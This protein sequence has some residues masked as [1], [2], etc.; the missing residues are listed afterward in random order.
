[1]SSK[2]KRYIS[3]L[4]KFITSSDKRA[5]VRELKKEISGKG[6]SH[7]VKSFLHQ[8]VYAKGNKFRGS[9][10]LKPFEVKKFDQKIKL[11]LPDTDQP[12]IT[13][14]IPMYNQ[15]DYTFDCIYSVYL[16]SGFNDYEILVA[17][18]NSTENSS[19]LLNN[20]KHLRVIKNES[21]L[22]F[23][24]NCKN[25]AAQARGK[26]L[27]FLNNDTY[28]LKNWLSE[29]LDIFNRL[30]NVGIV[31]SKLV[32]QDG[33]LQE[34]GGILWQ[35]GSGWNY[36]NGDFPSKSEY[37]YIKEADYVSGA[38][39]MISKKIWDE[40]GGFDE[41]YVPAYYEDTDLCFQVRKSGYKVM[42][43]PFSTV[44]HFEGISHGKNINKGVKQYQI[45]N[46]Q[47]FIEK[48]NDVLLH[49]SRNAENVF[50]ERDRSGGKKHI[51]I[52]DHYLPQI[53][54][55]AGSKCISNFIDSLLD[56]GYFVQ[57]LGENQN[58][59]NGYQEQFQKKGI[60]VLYGH[61]FDFYNQSYCDYLLAN[62]ANID[63]VLLSRSS[64]CLPVLIFLRKNNFQGNIIY[65][66]H[67][68]GYLRM[69][70][71][72]LE[73]KDDLLMKS[74]MK[75][76]EAEDFMY[77]NVDNSLVLSC[78]EIE[79]LETYIKNPLHYVPAY[80]FDVIK[81]EADYE[82]RSGI[83]F[84]GGFNHPPNSDAIIWFLNEIYQSIHDTNI[85][86]T[87]VGSHMPQVVYEYQ[88]RYPLLKILS[89][90]TI[91]DLNKLYN[92]TRIA[93]VPLRY[94]A[95]V[96]GKVIE[97]MSLGVP[98][99]GTDIAFEGMPK[100]GKFLYKGANNPKD[101]TNGIMSIYDNK[102]LWLELSDF[103]KA[104]VLENYNKTKMMEV[105]KNVIG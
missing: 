8:K 39:L 64:V 42:Y 70:K 37:N 104:Y 1:M 33:K 11:S 44:V 95:G 43:Q 87:I 53:D 24:R 68:L 71:E 16:N 79:Y 65:F 94:G 63:V 20:F 84:V 55:D 26:Y 85:P 14:I 76:K 48:W 103:G 34:A 13:I 4:N 88:K 67:D 50:S 61:E 83:L 5:L 74:A 12:L 57:F 41:R 31:G 25:A 17:D 19:L 32:Y 96:K 75:L 21:N 3:Y 2:I 60:E 40:I 105:F 99:V 27:I 73:K 51:L 6:V 59:G 46:Q 80:F 18:D 97:A 66:G 81:D 82:S 15:L 72:A 52:V 62:M 30:A 92:N 86:L 58:T 101:I 47:K 29:L 38:S 78:K 56:L 49:K 10:Q 54:K 91:S 100:D 102:K 93:V 45:V 89:N 35:D 77:Q 69:E 9:Q 7:G 98:I 22:G 36:G 90:V 28:V 23:L